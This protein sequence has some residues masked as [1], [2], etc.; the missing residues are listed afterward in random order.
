MESLYNLQAS[1]RK[2]SVLVTEDRDTSDPALIT[3]MFM[4][5]IEAM[6]SY[7]YP[8]ILRKR[9][10]DDINIRNK[11]LPWRRLPFWLILRVAA[12]RHLCLTLGNESGRLAYKLF[13]CLL[14]ADLLK[15]SAG[16]LRPE[17]TITLRTKLCRR[18]VKVDKDIKEIKSTKTEAYKLLSAQMIPLIKTAVEESTAQVDSA[19]RSFKQATTRRIP[20]LPLRAPVN[21]LQLSLPNSGRYLDGLLSYQPSSQP[22]FASFD[23]PQPPDKAVRQTQVF[24]DRIF[25]LAAMEAPVS[26]DESS[27]L[28]IP[29]VCE[30]RCLQLANSISEVFSEVGSTYDSDP[31]QLSIMIL[32]IFELWVRLDKHAVAACPLLGKYRPVFKPELLDVLQLPTVLGMRRL[33]DIQ[34][35]LNQRQSRSQYGTIFDELDKSCLAVRYVSESTELKSLATRIQAASDRARDAKKVELKNACNEFDRHTAAIADGIC[36]CSWSDGKRNVKGCKK[37]WHWRVRNRLMIQVQ[38][39]FLPE[40]DPARSALVFELALPSYFSVYRD[41]TWRIL[42]SLAH[43]GRPGNC[44]KPVIRLQ[45]CNPLRPYMTAKA[46]GISL[47]SK[48]KCFVQTHYKLDSANAPLSHVILP[49]AA[50]FKL[51]DNA[52]ELWVEDLRETP[53]LQHICGVHIPRGL[54]STILPARQHPLPVFDGPSSYDVQSNQSECPSEM[55]VHEFS[56][57]Q[58]VLAGTA[59]RWPNILVEM[60]SSNLNF[61]SEETMRVLCQLAIQAGPQLRGEALRKV[62]IIFEEPAFVESLAEQIQRRLH[63]ILT[64]WREHSCMELLI[65]LSLRLF[66]LSSGNM[67]ERA[68]KLLRTARDATLDWIGRLRNEIRTTTA[69][70]VAQRTATYGFY[71]ALLCRQTFATYTENH[72]AINAEDLSNWIRAS[73]ALQE[74][75]TIDVDTLPQRSKSMLIRDMKMAYHIQSLLQDAIASYPSSVGSA[76]AESWSNS[77]TDATTTSFCPWTFLKRPH[78]RWIVATASGTRHGLSLSQTVHYNIIEGHVLVD[79]KTRGKLPLEI[80]N[81]PVV[82]ELFGNQHLLTFP[83]PV[84]GMT[85]RL[86]SYVDNQEIHFGMRHNEVVV[87]AW[88]PQDLLEF[89]PKIVFAGP[90]NF[91]LPAELVENCVHW[92]N[93][94]TGCLEIRRRP[95]I[96]KKRDRDW[97]VDIPGRRARRGNVTLVNPQS[98]L[99]SQVASVFHRFEQPEKLTV[100]QPIAKKGTLSVELRH[101]ELSFYVNDNGLLECRQLKAEVDPDQDAGTWYGLQSKIVLRD[102]ISQKRSVIIPLGEVKCSRRGMHVD[103][104]INGT[105]EYARYNIDEILCR[106]SCPPEP[107]LLYTSALCHA[108]TSFC[109]P[110]TLTGRTGTQ[111]AF[112]ILRSGISQPWNPEKDNAAILRPLEKLSPRREYYPPEIKRLQKITWEEGLTMT[113]QHDGFAPLVQEIKKKASKLRNFAISSTA[114]GDS[115][116]SDSQEL[117]HLHYRGEM[118]RH[119]YERPVTDTADYTMPSLMIYTPRDR[120]ATSKAA[121]VYEIARLILGGWSSVFMNYKLSSLLESTEIIGGFH[122]GTKSLGGESLISQ[123]EE[124]IHQQWGDL[125]NF[126]RLADNTAPVLFRLGLLAF[127]NN[128]DMDVIRCLAAFSLDDELKSLQPPRDGSFINFKSRGRPSLQLLE[129]YIAPAY[130]EFKVRRFCGSIPRDEARRSSQEHVDLCKEEGRKFAHHVAEQWPIS[131]DKLTIE[132]LKTEVIDVSLAL[133]EIRSEWERR[134]QNSMLKAYVHKVQTILDS[135]KGPRDRSAPLKWKDTAPTFAGMR[136]QRIIPSIAKDLVI[137]DSHYIEDTVLD[138]PFKENGA[139]LH[140]DNPSSRTQIA[141]PIVYRELECILN[142]FGRSTDILR[143]NYGND[144]LRSLTALK[145]MCQTDAQVTLPAL[146]VSR[147]SAEEARERVRLHFERVS[148]TLSDKESMW[149]RLGNLWPCRSPTEVLTL[150]R[151]ASCHDFGAGTKEALVCYG[152]EIANLQRLE[153]IYHA[154]LREDRRALAEELQNPGHENWSPLEFPD[155]LLLEIDGNFLIRAEQVDVARAIITPQ[156]GENSVLQMN[157]GKGK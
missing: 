3:Q 87:R 24:T 86:T 100:Y 17:L 107:R 119:L 138:T 131:A 125:V 16:K 63:A 36:R 144:L 56:A 97:E 66:N 98:D 60:G 40:K 9:V 8:P 146:E 13:I 32:T 45:D 69:A 20:R 78:N 19:W 101:L 136:H 94:T 79:G 75:L 135:R 88:T 1:T 104:Y 76:I 11:G 137:K 147:D 91:D 67:K 141:Y 132:D 41:A 4:S 154:S 2:A 82:K 53:T 10:R 103:A 23:L 143:R 99:F 21:S 114:T 152:L 117:I 156:T 38:E 142:E 80:S 64:N 151:S 102:V 35:Y 7:Y 22:R 34:T 65:I 39:E 73:V 110:D 58:K 83:S 70:D 111:E 15:E 6:G 72:Q 27:E 43:P 122:S 129:K 89:V 28:T 14:L 77:A 124:P 47:A 55:S 57:Y 109:I 113:I 74:N 31:E 96:W 133:A 25:R 149:L 106:L 108:L 54:R 134:R 128:P 5:I 81:S 26:C 50:H 48:I 18:M 118:Q 123:V 148:V 126:C 153:R 68:E 140:G 93:L 130:P 139:T 49:L 120:M 44:K 127:G 37:C 46:K 30:A 105:Q 90:D 42:S 145:D 92:L 59:R 155:W 115:G 29:R 157:M 95:A 12:Q 61:S 33:Q 150:L 116:G 121:N 62:H 84:P 85:H 51:Y 71:A 112:S 52:S